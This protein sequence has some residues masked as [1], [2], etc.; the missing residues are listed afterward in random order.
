MLSEVMSSFIV[1]FHWF[2]L[3]STDFRSVKVFRGVKVSRSVKVPGPVRQQAAMLA[4]AVQVALQTKEM[5]EAL[6]KDGRREQ[7]LQD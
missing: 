6:R 4:L 2:P 5:G 7:V 3:T 1:M